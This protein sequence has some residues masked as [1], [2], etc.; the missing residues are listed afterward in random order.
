MKLGRLR[1][2]PRPPKLWRGRRGSTRWIVAALVLSAIL[3][4][5][6]VDAARGL[7]RP[8][9]G[10]CRVANV[11]DGDTLRLWC[12]GRGTVQAR[13]V[14]FDTPELASPDCVTEAV[15]AVRAKWALRRAIWGAS[16]INLSF[17]G[18][19]RYGRA[20]VDVTLDGVPLADLMIGLGHARPYSGGRRDSWC[21][22]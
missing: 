12:A 7:F 3:G 22:V 11:V 21:E 8:S 4:P 20:L 13:L 5:S 15:A 14:G 6:L 16:E 17:Q 1:A 19:D 10:D 9:A 2:R 18:D